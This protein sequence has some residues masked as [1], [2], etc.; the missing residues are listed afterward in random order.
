MRLVRLLPER[1]QKF[2]NEALKFGIVGGI[3]TVINYAVFNIL[4]LTIF[5]G[6]QLKATVVATI[7][8][9]ITSYLM[10]RHWTYRDRP[11]SALRR[12]TSLFFLFN[13]T[14]LAIELGVLAAAK[15]GFGITGL[16]ALN[17]AKTLGIVLATLFRFW[18]YRTFVFRNVPATATPET[19][20]V[21]AL[22]PTAE[23][24]E[25]ANELD[26]AEGRTETGA[27]ARQPA[28]AQPAADTGPT[29]DKTGPEHVRPDDTTGPEHVRPGDT[30]GPE[31]AQ[32]A[33]PER[34]GGRQP[35]T[36]TPTP[37]TPLPATFKDP[38]DLELEE[39]IAS[40]L[41]PSSRRPGNR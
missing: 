4:A 31:H 19:D 11:K 34:R 13:A 35:V 14:G 18:S 26:R 40:E 6:G 30:T 32:P 21:A 27:G 38:I 22:D 39:Q 28:A 3:N 9:T 16:L 33:K 25:T 1:W 23:V 36:S 5:L 7:V 8:A 29:D 15:Y 24:A 10:N 17:G 2:I 37:L 12:E 20:A 41:H